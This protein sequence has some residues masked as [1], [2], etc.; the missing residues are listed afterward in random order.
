MKSLKILHFFFCCFIFVDAYKIPHH[1]LMKPEFSNNRFST[2]L[3]PHAEYK[4]A[5]FFKKRKQ[6]YERKKSKKHIQKKQLQ[7]IIQNRT[8]PK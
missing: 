5:I 7:D 8:S 2:K 4:R 6:L 1:R 3:P